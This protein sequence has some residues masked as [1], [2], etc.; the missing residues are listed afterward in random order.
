MRQRHTSRVLA[1]TVL[2]FAASCSLF[3]WGEDVSKSFPSSPPS[4]VRLERVQ[5]FVFQQLH[6]SFFQRM[7]DFSGAGTQRS[8]FRMTVDAKGRI[9]VTDPGSSV[10]HVVEM[11]HRTYRQ[12]RGVRGHSL[13]KPLG[14][15]VDAE[16]NFYVTDLESAGVLVFNPK[17]HFLRIIGA[18]VLQA[19]IGI[20]VDK[21]ARRLYVADAGNA[22]VFSFDLKGN[23]LQV[24]G[25]SGSGPGQFQ[26]PTDVIR[27]HDR[28]VVV[29]AGNSRLQVFDLQGNL[30]DI[31]PLLGDRPG[32]IGFDDANNLYYVELIT[33]H[34]V[35]LDSR[36]RPVATAGDLR[37]LLGE[38]DVCCL[39]VRPNGQVMEMRSRLEVE[40]LK[41]ISER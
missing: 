23:V 10:V 30:Q 35:V 16:D 24:L 36:R 25:S 29:D 41:L 3:A 19:P 13:R 7:I 38:P 1:S 37:P 11:E 5:S 2:F 39:W 9:L 34:L 28:I 14:I 26:Y 17:G 31:W 27:H 32:S 12:I 18:A 22:K 6:R 20:W 15:S 40:V 4:R 8:P 33:G 21:E